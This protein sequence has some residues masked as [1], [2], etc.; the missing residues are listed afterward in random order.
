MRT[1]ALALVALAGCTSSPGATV[2]RDA[3]TTA[4]PPVRLACVYEGE[5]HR[6]RV[7]AVRDD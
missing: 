7:V 6:W 5:A 3:S 1:L 2:E 4:T